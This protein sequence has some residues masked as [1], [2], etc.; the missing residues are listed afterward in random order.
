M[1]TASTAPRGS[2]LPRRASVRRQTRDAELATGWLTKAVAAGY[3]TRRHLAHMT[4][5]SDL[6]ALRERPDFRRLL[7]ELFDRGFP[8]D[9]FAK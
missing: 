8:A 6:D 4:R 5:G 7:A 3:N 2:K 1:P 9:P